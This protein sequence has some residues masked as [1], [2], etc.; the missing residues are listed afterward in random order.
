MKETKTMPRAPRLPRMVQAQMDRFT[1]AEDGAMMPMV[2]FF[3][4]ITLLIGGMGVDFMHHE[5]E[6]VKLQ[7]VL[8]RAVLAAANTRNDLDPET[9]V[10]DYFEKAE[11]TDYLKTVTVESGTGY[12]TVSATASNP[13]KTQ[14][15]STLG[16]STLDVNASG[17]AEESIGDA[18]V[19]L[20][21]DISGS[22]ASNSRIVNM[23]SAA[24]E[25]IDTVITDDNPGTVSVSVV[26]YSSQVNA[27]PEILSRLNVLQTQGYSHC[28]EFDEDEFATTALDTTTLHHQYAHFSTGSSSN[29]SL[30]TDTEC[31]QQDYERITAFSQDADALK[32]QIGDL[33]ARQNTSIHLG[34]KWGVALLDPAFQ[35]V[36]ADMVDDGLIDESFD[37]RP[38]A[39]GAGALKTIVLMTDGANVRTY[40]LKDEVYETPDMRYMWARKGLSYMTNYMTSNLD[41]YFYEN[42]YTATEGDDLL[43][44]ICDAAKARGVIVWTIGFEV[45]NHGAEVMENCASSAAHFYRVEGIEIED[46]F[47]SIARQLNALHLVQ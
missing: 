11:M 1:R 13:M 45:S 38:V 42:A 27:G 2:L 10:R 17:T 12:R 14:F 4:V 46:A 28:M 30:V 5:M 6:R 47:A 31:P 39:W 18:E 29:S 40:R 33:Q 8:D 41:S 7:A 3:F 15:I 44:E 25:F 37:G 23:R 36:V 24:Q 34:M 19:S 43:E 22:M 20:V 21:L 35:P 32:E 9:V 16:Y 26:P